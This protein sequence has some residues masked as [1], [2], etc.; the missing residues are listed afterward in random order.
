MPLLV[1][2]IERREEVLFAKLFA[3]GVRYSTKI[4]H[5]FTTK[6]VRLCTILREV[7]H[8]V[9]A[10]KMVK[11]RKKGGLRVQLVFTHADKIFDILNS[12]DGIHT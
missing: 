2:A 6:R 4:M 10:V 5:A 3:S 9:K 1:S 8:D 7:K 12:I 11:Q